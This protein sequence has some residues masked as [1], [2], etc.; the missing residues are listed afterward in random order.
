MG[1]AISISSFYCKLEGAYSYD[2]R[3]GC[4]F[5]TTF[6][7]TVTGVLSTID[8]TAAAAVPIALGLLDRIRGIMAAS[9]IAPAVVVGLVERICEGPRMRGGVLILMRFIEAF[10]ERPIVSVEERPYVIP[11]V[12][13]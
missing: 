9:F 12:S 6:L 13:I 11:D 2:L 8:L 1:D 3:V 4:F 7:P 10:L 5:V